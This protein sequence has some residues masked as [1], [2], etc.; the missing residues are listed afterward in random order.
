[1]RNNYKFDKESFRNKRY[2][3]DN[4]K[5]LGYKNKSNNKIIRIWD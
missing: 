3:W 2:V 5:K 1:M 4:N